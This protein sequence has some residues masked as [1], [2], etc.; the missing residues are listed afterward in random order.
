[1]EFITNSEGETEALGVRLAEALAMEEKLPVKELMDEALA[2]SKTWL[3]TP[4]G[5]KQI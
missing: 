4:E 1:M 2:A 3:A 5:V